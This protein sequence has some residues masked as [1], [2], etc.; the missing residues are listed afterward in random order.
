MI[1]LYAKL[2]KLM[3]EKNF[4]HC[5]IAGDFNLAGVNWDSQSY[6]QNPPNGKTI[7]TTAIKAMHDPILK[8]P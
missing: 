8:V 7:N 5:I 4:R 1:S 3:K 6:V 2:Q